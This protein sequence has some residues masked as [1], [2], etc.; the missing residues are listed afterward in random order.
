MQSIDFSRIRVHEGSQRKGFEDFVCQLANR[1]KPENALEFIPKE[2]AGGDAGVE[3]Y[4]K[5]IDGSEH[6]WQAKY[7][8]KRLGKSQWQQISKSVETALN[9][10]PKLTKY[11]V[12]L[13]IDLTETRVKRNGQPILSE[14]DRWNNY[15]RKWTEIAAR[16]S[17]N[18]EFVFWGKLQIHSVILQSDPGEIANFTQYWFGATNGTTDAWSHRRF[19]TDLVDQEV[20]KATNTLRKC[21][22]FDEFEKVQYS[23]TLADKLINGELSEGS[24]KSRNKALAWCARIL[25]YE[26]REKAEEC[27]KY[28]SELPSCQE[29]IIAEAFLTSQAGKKNDALSKLAEIDSLMSRTAAFLIVAHHEGWESAINWLESACIDAKNLDPDG[30]LVLLKCQLD[31]SNWNA[32]QETCDL[33]TDDD[34]SEAPC[35][36]HL[37][38]LTY[39]LSTVQVD[40]RPLVL[41]QVPFN[42]F[43]FPLDDN[44][45]ALEARRTAHRHFAKV[46][47]AALDLGMPRAAAIAEEYAIWLELKD[48]SRLENGRKRLLDRFRNLDSA[49]R[50]VRLGIQFG[51]KLDLGAVE[52]EITRQIALNG[53]IT[54][55]TALARFALVDTKDTPEQTLA[56]IDRHR[57]E[58]ASLIDVRQLESIRFEMLL[59]I[60]QIEN[61]NAV[62]SLLIEDGLPDVEICRL[63]QLIAEAEGTDPIEG[64]KKQFKKT[65]S[66]IDLEILI[67]ELEKRMAWDDLC[68]Y[69]EIQF[70]NTRTLPDA[71]LFAVA[72]YNTQR[73]RQLAEFLE[74]NQFLTSRSG[75]LQLLNCWTLYYNG[76]LQE[77]RSTIEELRELW[78]DPNYRELRVNIGISL[79]D[80]NSVS[81]VVAHECENKNSRNAEELIRTA[82]LAFHLGLPQSQIKE[83]T[84]AAV[85]KASDN[86]RVLADAYYLASVDGWENTEEASCWLQQ[87]VALSGDDGPIWKATIQEFA[88][89]KPEWDRIQSEIWMKLHRGELPMYGAGQALNRSLIHLM[90]YPF[91]INLTENDPRRR[92]TVFAYS[93]RKRRTL[94]EPS[95]KIAIDVSVL[96][97]LSSLNV[98]DK[99]LDAFEE[100]HISHSTLGWFFVERMKA[101]FHQP[102]RISDAYEIRRILAEGALDKL[103]HGGVQHDDLTDQVGPELAQLITEAETAENGDG[104]QRIVVCP[105][106]VHRAGSLMDEEAD[107]TMHAKVLASCTSIV[108]ELLRKGRITAREE[109]RARVYLRLHEKPWPEQPAIAN[110]ATLY[111]T[112]LATTYFQHLGLLE[113]LKDAGFRSLVSPTVVSEVDQLISY[114][115]TSDKIETTIERIRLVL[116]KGI[117]KG[118]VITDRRISPIKQS[119][120]H[121]EPVEQSISDHPTAGI[122]SLANKHDAIV[123]DDR[124]IGQYDH[125]DAESTVTPVFSSLDVIDALV[126]ADSISNEDC[127]EYRTKLRNAGYIFVPLGVEELLHHLESAS[128]TNGEVVGAALSAIRENLLL[129]RLSGCKLTVEED[130]WLG[131][132]F[133]TLRETFKELWKRGGTPSDVQARSDWIWSQL[134]VR[135]W[136]HCFERETGEDLVKHGYLEQILSLLR[137]PIEELQDDKEDYWRWV[138]DRILGPIKEQSP[139][140]YLKLVEWYRGQIDT[141]VDM[142]DSAGA[143]NE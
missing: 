131:M 91:F 122:L 28:A 57:D 109:Q 103:M 33:L 49:L 130:D 43:R 141:M 76:R 13:P 92:G 65:N 3:C 90:L 105:G 62:L 82:Q 99:V 22:F 8:T 54:I 97:T 117:A 19:P 70:A 60:G 32:A 134:D 18:V 114:G 120:P 9:K 39:L 139:E 88:D 7:F 69:G 83:L 124:F 142:Y 61:A 36:H 75:R 55:D 42:S 78:D 14:R 29:T 84:L 138:E 68:E 5:L 66:S 11:Y 111:L 143:G 102:S 96:L 41:S 47:V 74:S 15:V 85:E 30:K 24:A 26:N 56:Y 132:L 106:P 127:M 104:L 121:H 31:F 12:C 1:L 27:L 81:T 59:R 118:K 2:G 67:S 94:L 128:V 77:A 79:G 86:A 38:A 133:K 125:I 71:E 119:T 48:P 64:L 37:V 34:Y 44:E 107:L 40:L 52:K 108:E 116:R 80:W 110:G 123:V 98:L 95:G 63:R 100:I 136:A 87:A 126:A 25:S 137:L 140:T 89:Q 93:G 112:N 73:I 53:K 4:W 72:L 10:H 51:V 21:R 6:A 17:M 115:N 16:Q 20:K 113:K 129:V 50:F 135:I 45:S 58:I 101:M 23:S 46:Q 35:L